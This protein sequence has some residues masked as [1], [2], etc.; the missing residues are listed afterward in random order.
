MSTLRYIEYTPQSCSAGRSAGDKRIW[1]SIPSWSFLMICI[2]LLHRRKNVLNMCALQCEEQVA[3]ACR[4]F[5]RGGAVQSLIHLERKVYKG[6]TT[7]QTISNLGAL[8][9]PKAIDVIQCNCRHLSWRKSHPLTSHR[10]VCSATA[11]GC[12]RLTEVGNVKWMPFPST[13]AMKQWLKHDVRY[14]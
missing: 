3:V 9:L 10:A 13:G 5:V 8:H 2:D 12:N 7:A 11:T 6:S 14:E 4:E 1:E